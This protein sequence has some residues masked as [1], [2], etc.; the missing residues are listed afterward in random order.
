MERNGE[1][2][3]KILPINRPYKL[4]LGWTVERKLID[5]DYVIFN[6]QP[7]LHKASMMAMQILIKPGK[8]IRMNLACTKGYNA[9]FNTIGV[10]QGA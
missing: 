10:K 1:M 5:D 7:T 6:R 3:D 9:D 8:T 4:E 2:V